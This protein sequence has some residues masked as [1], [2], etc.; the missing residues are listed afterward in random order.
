V[1][2]D[3]KLKTYVDLLSEVFK[4]QAMLKYAKQERMEF[5][6]LDKWLVYMN[7]V[8]HAMVAAMNDRLKE[9][10]DYD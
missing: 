8:S 1:I 6:D 9:I 3:E 4:V 10:G 2:E 7:D 5:D